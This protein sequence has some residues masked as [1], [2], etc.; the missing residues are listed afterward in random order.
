MA[1]EEMSKNKAKAVGVV[2]AHMNA[3]RWKT[4]EMNLLD[5]MRLFPNDFGFLKLMGNVKVRQD[6]S[7]E[8]ILWF[9]KAVKLAPKNTDIL[10]DLSKA[11]LLSQNAVS[12]TKTLQK[13][14]KID[15]KFALGWHMLAKSYEVQGQ[16]AEAL[17]AYKTTMKLQPDSVVAASDLLSALERY[18][19]MDEMNEALVSISEVAPEHPV[20]KTFQGIVRF[21]EQ[22]FEKAK[23]LLESVTLLGTDGSGNRELESMRIQYLAKSCD[24]LGLGNEA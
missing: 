20:V 7:K 15:P 19:R 5:A 3:G 1:V 12:A 2:L 24:Q 13:A 9:K 4:A 11:E 22:E 18:D 21:R 14:V 17:N 6:Q 8:A 10:L 16:Q 23:E